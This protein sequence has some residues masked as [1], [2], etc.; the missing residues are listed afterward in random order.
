MIDVTARRP[1]LYFQ[2]VAWRYERGSTLIT[3]NEVVTQW[4]MV[5]GDEVR[6]AAILDT[7][8]TTATR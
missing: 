5:F 2:V 6:A 3:T 7:C 1:H 8:C 4:A